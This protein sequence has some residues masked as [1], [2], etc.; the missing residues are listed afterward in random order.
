VSDYNTLR[1][2]A[3][4]EA[5]KGGLGWLWTVGRKVDVRLVLETMWFVGINVGTMYMFLWRGFYWR[6]EDGGVVD[7]GRVQRFMW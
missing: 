1:S 7:G 3:G 4:G 5:K 2:G 6:G